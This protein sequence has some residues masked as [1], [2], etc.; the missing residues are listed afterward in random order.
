MIVPFLNLDREGAA[1]LEL[2]L[3][4]DIESVI[5]SGRFLFGP[6]AEEF[7][8]RLSELYE[9][10]VVLV[11]SGTDALALSLKALGVGPGDAVAIPAISAIPTAV[12][13]KMVGA[14]P[15]Y[16]DVDLGLTMDPLCLEAAVVRH[17]EMKAV[18][19]VHL[20]GNPAQI[21]TIHATCQNNGL[22]LVEDCAQS[23]GA[24]TWKHPFGT[25]GSAGALSFYPTKNLGCM[26]DG[27]A[28]IACDDALA[29]ALRE[30]RFYGQKNRSEM[31]RLIGM[32]SRMDE[33][34]CAI[35]LRKLQLLPE[36]F[37]RRIE[38]KVAYDAAVSKTGFT[39]PTWRPGAVPHLYP[40]LTNDRQATINA[41]ADRGVETAI[42][43]PFHLMEA[44]EGCPG[45]GAL[46]RAK[47]HVDR[48]LSLPFNPWM[49]DEEV[50]HVLHSLKE[51]G[52]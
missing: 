27:G 3:M 17:P 1:L 19:P 12:A 52:G 10:P 31:G 30:L 46:S 15:L 29:Q 11:G 28:V 16:I 33:L 26:G 35:L 21:D 9:R 40:I 22:V 42:H 18:M 20:Y 34:Q 8:S 4:S 32:N 7:E 36:Q 48:V 47:E 44:V 49:T 39:T 23:F 43:Y 6:K 51:V 2:G 24:R 45:A 14:N 5:M 13:V 41:L 50:E 37:K 25:L 38:M